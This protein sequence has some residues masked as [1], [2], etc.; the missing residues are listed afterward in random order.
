LYR[1]SASP[2]PDAV[3]ATEVRQLA[4]VEREHI[5][6]VLRA[7]GGNRSREAQKLG[8]GEATL[9][10]KIKQLGDS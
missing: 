7:V 2:V 3:V 1:K 10:R 4:E 5:E 6:S 8:I 9:Y